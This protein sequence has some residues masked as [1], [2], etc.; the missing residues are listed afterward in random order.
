MRPAAL[1]LALFLV[2]FA[3]AARAQGPEVDVSHLPGP[4][5]EAAIAVDPSNDQI[6]LAGSNSFSEGTM[7]AYG[8]T[9]GGATWRATTVYPAPQKLQ[10]TC[11]ADPGVAIDARG[12]QYFSFVRS[13]PCPSGP[14]R[15]Y[16]ASRAGPAA[17]WQKP[18]LVAPLR[19]SRFDDK[20]AIA[21][22]DSAA[23]R[24]EKRVYVAW[25]RISHNGVYS[26]LVSHSD[27]AGRTWSRPVKANR[28]GSEE[29]YAT[30][31][32]S[33]S[34]ILYVAWDDITNFHV[35]ITRSTDG[36]AH[37][38]PEREVVA[39]AI[40][41]IP[42]CGAGIVI[43]AQRFTCLQPNPI[44]SVDTSAGPFSGRVYVTY[45]LTDF[46]GDRGAA[47]T[48]FDS[49]LRA[50]AGYPVAKAALLIAP[51][52][53]DVN[54]DQFWPASGVDPSTGALWACFYDTRGDPKRTS[55]FY[56]C[57]V[58]SDGGGT[59]APPVHAATAASDETQPGAD[60]HEYGDYEGFAVAN[61]KAHPIW[62]DSRDLP[63]LDEEIYT[64]TL[65]QA[66]FVR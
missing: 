42:H 66:D 4:Q 19:S 59:W 27:D 36:G 11:A 15:L 44:V 49:R 51:T 1:A 18:V 61:G 65:T 40:V 43:P 10:E 47:L 45:A 64:T 57:S 31:A 33:R 14:P 5:S 2:G 50:L 17:A 6:L 25:T 22:D 20:P 24:Y 34:G 52:P 60:P 62:T 7:R 48:I 28:T 29:S 56:S 3:P 30:V 32:V 12:T 21:V 8:S 23:S 55:A 9:D 41:T 37:F 58:S 54:A 13:K 38:E 46:Q 53:R 63:T 35:N 39:F 16:V 26:I